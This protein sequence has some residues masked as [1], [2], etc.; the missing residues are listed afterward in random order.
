MNMGLTGMMSK[1]PPTGG[2][3]ELRAKP[4]HLKAFCDAAFRHNK[5]VERNDTFERIR[6]LLFCAPLQV[7]RKVSADDVSIYHNYNR[8]NKSSASGANYARLYTVVACILLCEMFIVACI[9]S[10]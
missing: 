1:P 7:C 2:F 8:C 6:F 10:M 5:D 3:Q 4:H 9:L